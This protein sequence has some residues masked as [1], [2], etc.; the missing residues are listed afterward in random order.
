MTPEDTHPSSSTTLADSQSD[1]DSRSSSPAAGEPA[2]PTLRQQ[3]A[4]RLDHC[5]LMP[6]EI[7]EVLAG[8]INEALV[9]NWNRG[10]MPPVATSAAWMHVKR[11]AITWMDATAPLHFARTLV[12]PSAEFRLPAGLATE[13]ESRLAR[14]EMAAG[15]TEGGES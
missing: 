14:D 11:A 13:E 7:E 15:E 4:D 6:A 3:M 9:R 1:A 2:E 5:G 10:G 8:D 12:D